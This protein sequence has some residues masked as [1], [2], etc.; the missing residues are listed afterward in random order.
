MQPVRTFGFPTRERFGLSEEE[1]D[2]GDE[3]RGI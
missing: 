1:V 2:E 3:K